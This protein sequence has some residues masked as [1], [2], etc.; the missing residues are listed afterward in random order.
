MSTAGEWISDYIKVPTVS[1]VLKWLKDLW[2][3]EDGV[4]AKFESWLETTKSW[5][6]DFWNLPTVQEFVSDLKDLWPDIKKEFELWAAQ[7]EN[8]PLIS[9]GY[10]PPDPESPEAK[11]FMRQLRDTLLSIVDAAI[12]DLNI[13]ESLLAPLVA[14]AGT[15]PVAGFQG[16]VD[17]IVGILASVEG[18]VNAADE[19]IDTFFENFNPDTIGPLMDTW[20]AAI[21]AKLSEWS[22]GIGEGFRSLWGWI[23]DIWTAAGDDLNT[24]STEKFAAIQLN[25]SGK[26]K[27]MKLAFQIAW[28]G[29]KLIWAGAWDD[30]NSI[31]Q[32]AWGSLTLF[33]TE[34][35][36]MLGNAFA[37]AMIWINQG[38]A[39]GWETIKTT[40]AS[41]WTEIQATME[42]L[43]GGFGEWVQARVNDLG[44]GIVAI[45]NSIIG[46]INSIVAAINKPIRAWNDLSFNVGRIGRSFTYPTGVSLEGVTTNTRWFGFPGFNVKTTDLPTLSPLS[47]IGYGSG[48]GGQQVADI[49]MLASGGLA[50]GPTLAMI[51]EKEPEAVLRM[52]Q[53]RD[54]AG[55]GGGAGKRELHVHVEN[56]YGVDDLVDKINEAWLDG[57]LRGLQDQ[58][59]GAG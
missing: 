33:L 50:M 5:I 48:G 30:L 25:L 37:I 28:A 16:I 32:T 40:V 7:A 45:A 56:A 15:D 44:N 14:I 36:A 39:A 59:A 55:M 6:S 8:R 19:A 27:F 58:L 3:G 51:G 53:L 49:S 2:G 21:G 41:A 35:F 1:E 9:F 38:W 12:G 17:K 24:L 46:V 26:L 10:D 57:R 18:A 31:V 23:T 52:D 42:N 13:L 43:F 29:V 20:A 22:A 34:S 47:Q 11:G 54:F 4:A